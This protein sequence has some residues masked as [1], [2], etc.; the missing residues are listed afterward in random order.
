YSFPTRRSSDLNSTRSFSLITGMLTLS[1][2]VSSKLSKSGKIGV[3]VFA[4]G[5]LIATFLVI[6]K[7]QVTLLEKMLVQFV[8]ART[9]GQYRLTVEE[10]GFDLASLTYHVRDITIASTDTASTAPIREIRIPFA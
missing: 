1:L 10:T 4:G 5:A 7:S 3:W 8:E 9:H 6:Q 2:I